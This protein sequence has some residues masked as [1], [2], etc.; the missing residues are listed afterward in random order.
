MKVTVVPAQITTVEDKIAGNLTFPQ[1]L[2]LVGSLMLAGAVYVLMP[3]RAHLS[4]EKLAVML[5][6]FT[7]LGTLALRVRGRLV[8]DW[9][10]L[11]L[12]FRSRP[13][14][15]IFTKNDLEF[16]DVTV[17]VPEKE[18][19][20]IPTQL[21]VKAVAVPLSFEEEVRMER[22][23]ANPSVTVRFALSKKGGMDVSLAQAE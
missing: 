8:A 11:L 16:R 22:M 1:V 7:I 15:Y 3:Q 4:P 5:G 9:L 10:V 13:R 17:A 18:Q 12:R 20:T 6:Q 23:L 21:P 2:L 19:A 14:V